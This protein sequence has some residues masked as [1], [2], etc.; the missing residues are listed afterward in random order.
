MQMPETKPSCTYSPLEELLHSVSH[1]IGLLLS[2]VG[3][4][5]LVDLALVRDGG[6]RLV[7]ACGVFGVTLILLYLAS[8]LYHGIRNERARRILRVLD[9]SAIYLLIAG[10]YTPFMLVSLGGAWGWSL[11]GIVWGLAIL[12]ILLKVFAM[13]RLRRL[14]IVLYLVMGWLALVVLGPMI[15]A[16]GP[17]GMWLVFLGGV[18]YTFG[19]IFYGWRRPYC[20]AIWHAFVL[21]GSILHFFAVLLY[22]IPPAAG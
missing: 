13:G 21:A 5:L 7:T 6:A 14:S 11:F 19:L 9:H 16:L 15:Q 4:V 1:G 22:V 17:K 3:L 2:I 12:G 8:T 18:A 20:H 10:T